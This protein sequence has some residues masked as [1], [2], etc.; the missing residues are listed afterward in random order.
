VVDAGPG[1][2]RGR[3]FVED[4]EAVLRSLL[5]ALLE[6]AVLQPELEDALFE[7]GETDLRVDGTEHGGLRS[8]KQR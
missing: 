8:G 4:E 7:G 5:D 1:V 2:G 3:A 6:D